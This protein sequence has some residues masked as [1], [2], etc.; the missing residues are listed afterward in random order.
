MVKAAGPV[1]VADENNQVNELFSNVKLSRLV[2]HNQRFGGACCLHL[3]S[4]MLLLDW[5]EDGC[6]KLL[7]DPANHQ[8]T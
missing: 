7:Q 6:S 3:Q 1:V 8:A 5:Q 2:I 4:S